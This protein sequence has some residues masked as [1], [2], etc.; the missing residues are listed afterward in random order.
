MKAIIQ[1]KYGTADNLVLAEIARP[2]AR[3]GEVLV[4]VQVASVTSATGTS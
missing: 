3:R 4:R 2:K 1:D